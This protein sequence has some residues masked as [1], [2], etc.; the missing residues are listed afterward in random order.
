MGKIHAGF[1]Q[2]HEGKRQFVRP[3]FRQ[4]DNIKNYLKGIGLECVKWINVGG[5]WDECCEVVNNVMDLNVL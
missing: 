3:R 4:E 5:D 1:F 2:K